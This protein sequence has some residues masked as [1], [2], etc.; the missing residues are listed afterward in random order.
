MATTFEQTKAASDAI[1]QAEKKQQDE[2]TARL[3]A[4]RLQ[5]E[6]QEEGQDTPRPVPKKPIKRK[7]KS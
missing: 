6:A 5:K 2:K 1:V 4:A 3:R 7:K